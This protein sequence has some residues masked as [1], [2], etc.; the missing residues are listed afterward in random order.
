MIRIR[1]DVDYLTEITMHHWNYLASVRLDYLEVLT[2][3]PKVHCFIFCS[4][5]YAVN[6]HNWMQPNMNFSWILYASLTTLQAVSPAN[7]QVDSSVWNQKIMNRTHNS[8]SMHCQ[9][10]YSNDVGAVCWHVNWCLWSPKL[11]GHGILLDNMD[12]DTVLILIGT[13]YSTCI[14]LFLS[15]NINIS[16]LKFK[17]VHFGV[18]F[19]P[20]TIKMRS[21]QQWNCIEYPVPAWYE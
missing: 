3:P 4:G 20:S 8:L 13:L 12:F 7:Q 21:N 16:F 9:K 15:V 11:G 17:V 14:W 6:K 18:I 5:I 19:L 1:L 10:Q 2:F